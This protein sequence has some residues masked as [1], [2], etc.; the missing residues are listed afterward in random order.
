MSQYDNPKVNQVIYKESGID[1]AGID[2]PKDFAALA[3]ALLDQTGLSLKDQRVV[4]K[5]IART[6]ART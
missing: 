2:N 6:L 3:M 4:E 5:I 1:A